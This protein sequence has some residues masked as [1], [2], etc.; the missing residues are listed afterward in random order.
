MQRTI[1]HQIGR[2]KS[3]GCGPES[4]CALTTGGAQDRNA[5]PAEGSQ[6][7][8][9]KLVTSLGLA[10]PTAASSPTPSI[11]KSMVRTPSGIGVP[12]AS[13]ISTVT[14]AKSL[15][16]AR[17]V[18]RSAC[19]RSFRRLSHGLQ[20]LRGDLLSVFKCDRSQFA[21]AHKAPGTPRSAWRIP[22]PAW[23]QPPC[24]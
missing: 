20:S 9:R 23:S 18:C 17:M 6:V 1:H 11:W 22:A 2:L 15:R 4:D 12:A 19:R 24:R 21:L 13:N 3:I 14:K 7:G 16:L 5:F 10:L 8:C